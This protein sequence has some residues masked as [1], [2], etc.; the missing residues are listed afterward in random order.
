MVLLDLDPP[1]QKTYPD[2]VATKMLTGV[3]AVCPTTL[4]R[5]GRRLFRHVGGRRCR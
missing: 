4:V 3:D 2:F 5:E 1:S